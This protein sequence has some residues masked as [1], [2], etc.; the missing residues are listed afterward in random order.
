MS[1]GRPA[2]TSIAPLIIVTSTI[3]QFITTSL[4][5]ARVGTRLQSKKP[6]Y[7]YDWFLVVAQSLSF[8][9]F[10]L[11]IA[12]TNH[13]YGRFR[14][15]VPFPST[16]NAM[17]YIF[18]AQLIFYWSAALV[19]ISVALLLIS[20][21]KFSRP[22]RIFLYITIGIVSGSLILVTLMQLT[23]CSK[24]SAYWDPRVMARSTC[25]PGEAIAGIIVAFSAVNIA[26]DVVYT[27]MPLTFLVRLNQPLHQRIIIA[28]LMSLG[29]FASLAAIFRTLGGVV[30][31]RDVFRN[32]SNITLLAMVELHM[33]VIA[34]TLPTL[35]S[36]FERVLR[37]MRIS[38]KQ[39]PT[40]ER[41]R[42]VL[43][44]AGLLDDMYRKGRGTVPG[45][46]ERVADL[47]MGPGTHVS[48]EK[49]VEG[50]R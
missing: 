29:L 33:G 9:A 20:L 13:G 3:L 2:D 23:A 40:E 42:E 39:Q 18:F 30:R 24:I 10:F 43:Y 45:K 27:C 37:G 16:V 49:P 22:W 1:D 50:I 8:P 15:F 6:L 32:S 28:I 36:F 25:W 4:V 44:Q 14:R 46:V 12:A 5:A 35:K 7:S 48:P 38:M 21:K 34:A 11:V 26:A 41:A 19:K 17:R 47:E 31:A